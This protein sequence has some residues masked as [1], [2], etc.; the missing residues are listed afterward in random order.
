MKQVIK[1]IKDRLDEFDDNTISCSGAAGIVIHKGKEYLIEY[2]IKSCESVRAKARRN[3]DNEIRKKRLTTL[4]LD[5]T[6]FIFL[7]CM[8]IFLGIKL[9]IEAL[10]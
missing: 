2:K 8:A 6:V 9:L 7:I 4:V 1:T 3:F 10:H 5:N